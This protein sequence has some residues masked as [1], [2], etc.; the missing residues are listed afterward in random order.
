MVRRKR[1]EGRVD[2]SKFVPRATHG[3]E[4]DSAE[5]A[6]PKVYGG[7]CQGGSFRG[8]NCSPVPFARAKGAKL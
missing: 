2:R 1:E 3:L 7:D 4:D 5:G 8:E 6:P